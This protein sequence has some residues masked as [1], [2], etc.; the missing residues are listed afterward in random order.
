MSTDPQALKKKRRKD[1]GN[2]LQSEGGVLRVVAEGIMSSKRR[3]SR[4]TISGPV[5][6]EV[7]QLL[8][9]YR[10]GAGTK[11]FNAASA[12]ELGAMHVAL[13]MYILDDPSVLKACPEG[14]RPYSPQDDEDDDGEE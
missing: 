12:A 2:P 8:E 7:A 14:L 6:T 11:S 5:Y 3:M 13:G 4:T 9:Q 1:K 10:T